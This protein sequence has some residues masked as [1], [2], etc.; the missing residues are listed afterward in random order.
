MFGAYQVGVWKALAGTF[1][2]DVV[3]GASAGALNAWVVASGAPPDDLE[4]FWLDPSGARLN[5]FRFRQPP[6]LGVFDVRPLYSRIEKLWSAYR[7]RTGVGVVAVEL[8]TLRPRLFR[9]EEITWKHLAASCA[10]L[11]CYPQVRLGTRFYTDGGLL[12]PLPVW[13]AVEMGARRIIAVNA[14]PQMPSRLVGA[15]VRGIQAVAPPAVPL[16]NGIDV[17]LISPGGRLGTLR[18][19]LFWKEASIRRWIAQGEA[20][21]AGVTREAAGWS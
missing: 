18:E 11:T 19:S 13:A 12:S 16:D 4:R 5:A 20:D 17:R 8:R 7:P 9:D 6:W 21:A 15:A 10:I 3:V 1:R 14:L 2:P